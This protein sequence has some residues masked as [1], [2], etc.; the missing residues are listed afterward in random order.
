MPVEQNL[1]LTFDLF[2]SFM[3]GRA[4][5]LAMEV[6]M[7]DLV[8]LAPDW[9]MSAKEIARPDRGFFTVSGVRVLRA[10]GR[11]VT[12][13]AQPMLAYQ[14]AGYVGLIVRKMTDFDVVLVRL[15]AEPGNVGVRSAKNKNTRVLVCPSIQFSQGNLAQH[16][17]AKRGELD[18]NGNPIKLVP[19]A[20]A[21]VGS[22][23]NVRW[24]SA[25][26]DGGRF[27]E[28]VNNYGLIHVVNTEEIQADLE[29]TGMMENYS[30]ISLPVLRDLCRLGLVSGHLR[31]CMS[32]LV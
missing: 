5:A 24:Q 9:Q 8:D 14:T 15:M 26:E 17:K 29:M 21:V 16:E 25:P 11:E 6:E 3:H 19:F 20:D 30:W 12:G 28:K 10:A 22:H 23:Y 32:L 13:W 27:F 1:N 18:K 7:C 2:Q 31:S 4:P